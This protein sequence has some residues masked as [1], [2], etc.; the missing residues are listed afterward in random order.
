MARYAICQ[1]KLKTLMVLRPSGDEL[2]S[3]GIKMIIK[4]HYIT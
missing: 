3:Y 1:A 4:L 2:V